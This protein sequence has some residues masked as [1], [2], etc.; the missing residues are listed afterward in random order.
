[1]RR[2]SSSIKLLIISPIFL[3]V[4]GCGGI[5]ET[6]RPNPELFGPAHPEMKSKPMPKN[7]SIYRAGHSMSLYRDQTAHRVGDILTI[8][9]EENTV[10]A[11]QANTKI[12]KKNKTALA[13]PTILGQKVKA[14]NSNLA[15]DLESDSAFDGKGQSDQKNSL[16]G[17]ITVT[18]AKVL[19]NG[20]MVIRG[21][22]WIKLNRGK[23][24]IR[25][26]GMIRPQDIDG[27]NSLSSNRV[28]NAR[29]TYSGTGEVAVSNRQGW[30]SR[31]F[32]A[33]W[34]F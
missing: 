23:E 25:L 28:A 2:I 15:F 4:T 34:P 13:N 7:G 20:N 30:L 22:T 26:T 32:S 29:I 12:T 5:L 6:A 24:Y 16:N 3:L 1:M 21:E 27:N 8:R 10:A 19:P 14:G 17:T 31:F 11:K 18:V 9:L 33:V